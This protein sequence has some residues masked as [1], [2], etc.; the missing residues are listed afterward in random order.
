MPAYNEAHHIREN[1]LITRALFRKAKCNFE[2]IVVDDGS[3]DDTYDQASL[4][5]KEDD[6]VKV[7]RHLTNHG[8]GGALKTGFKQ[9]TGDFVV[10]LDSDLDLPPQQLRNLFRIMRD[11]K[12]DVLIGS[13]WHPA[14]K[15]V[16]PRRRKIISK[17]YAFILWL[18][19]RLPLKDT[20]TGLKIFRYEVLKKVF[21][22]VLCKRFAF[23]VE[24]L[25]NAHRLGYKIVEAP[26]VLNFRRKQRWGKI[27]FM[28]LYNAGLDTLA[29][30]YRMY[31]L[32]YYDR[33][34]QDP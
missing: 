8:K 20:Q 34:R 16:Y 32:R 1:L 29:I 23:D 12:A 15:I 6:V 10:F 18:L 5:A 11:Q 4:V 21:D 2:I 27:T 33:K 14:A 28:D 9:A 24:V 7:I 26:V 31:I 25:T 19:F 30:F 22:L 3:N 13:K 17:F